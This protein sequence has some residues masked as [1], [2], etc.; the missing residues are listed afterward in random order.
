MGGDA[1]VIWSLADFLMLRLSL[2]FIVVLFPV[3]ISTSVGFTF[4][5][6]SGTL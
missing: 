6:F 1:Q 5:F 2:F 3:V 4:F